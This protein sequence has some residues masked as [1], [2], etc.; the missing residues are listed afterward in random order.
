MNCQL[1][2]E[3]RGGCKLNVNIVDTTLRD[4]EQ[5]ACVA[6]GIKEKVEIAKIINDMGITQIEAGIASMGGDEKTSIEKIVNLNLNSKISSWNR[7]NID[8]INHSMDC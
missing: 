3:K 7:M 1:C 4:G 2:I 8:D 5:K 6:L